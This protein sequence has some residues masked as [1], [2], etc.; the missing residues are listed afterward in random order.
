MTADLGAPAVLDHRTVAVEA[1]TSVAPVTIHHW[2][3]E[4]VQTAFL[5]PAQA[6]IWARAGRLTLVG[7]AGEE[8]RLTLL[9]PRE[10][11]GALLGAH[12]PL[13]EPENPLIRIAVA[14]AHDMG[15]LL[16][17]PAWLARTAAISGERNSEL[18]LIVRR[19]RLASPDTAVYYGQTF[20]PLHARPDQH[21]PY[22][23]RGLVG[24][25]GWPKET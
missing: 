9:A 10:A 20:G 3:G 19:I 4:R 22:D 11:A 13:G 6:Q 21:P 24:H 7:A 2:T 17:F 23:L 18:G 14:A 16:T 1:G 5:T 15:D 12:W 25:E 8:Y